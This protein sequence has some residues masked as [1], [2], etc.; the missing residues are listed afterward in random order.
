MSLGADARLASRYCYIDRM[1]EIFL[2]D[3]KRC[4]HIQT[5]VLCM[6]GCPHVC[7][8][9]A[10]HAFVQMPG[11]LQCGDRHASSLAVGRNSA[12]ATRMALRLPK[13]FVSLMRAV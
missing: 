2:L 9:T 12:R 5:C 7:V 1:V 3:L 13:N 4:Q 8:C 6:C 10:A 11:E